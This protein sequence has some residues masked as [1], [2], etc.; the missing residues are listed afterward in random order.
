MRIEKILWQHRRDFMA[1]YK[2]EHCKKSVTHTGYDDNNFHWNVVPS[3]ACPSCCLKA[4][5]DTYHPLD[6][7]Y[8]EWKVV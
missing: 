8:P 1:V 2:C 3:M 5:P 7:K 4:D 6:T